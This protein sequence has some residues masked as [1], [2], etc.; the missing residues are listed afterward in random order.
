MEYILYVNAVNYRKLTP[1]QTPTIQ[2][3]QEDNPCVFLMEYGIF[4]SAECL[5]SQTTS[6]QTATQTVLLS[7]YAKI[8]KP[9]QTHNYG[10]AK[11]MHHPELRGHV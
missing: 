6:S 8:K 10:L 11:P 9:S 4:V 7:I 5:A 3:T 2:P 1:A